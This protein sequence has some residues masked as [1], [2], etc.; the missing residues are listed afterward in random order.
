[1]SAQ[2]TFKDKN[3]DYRTYYTIC[4]NDNNNYSRILFHKIKWKVCDRSDVTELQDIWAE[5]IMQSI[6]DGFS[7]GDFGVMIYLENGEEEDAWLDWKIMS[8][9]DGEIN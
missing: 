7:Q 5:N 8:A 3:R 9:W 2:Y 6:I 4:D 1:M